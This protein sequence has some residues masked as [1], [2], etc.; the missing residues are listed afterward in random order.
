MNTHAINPLWFQPITMNTLHLFQERC[1]VMNSWTP[2]L[3]LLTNSSD[4]KHYLEAGLRP[5][6]V[7]KFHLD[8]HQYPLH[9]LED[10]KECRVSDSG[11]MVQIDDGRLE[12]PVNAAV[13][14]CRF[15]P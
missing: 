8:Y 10:L 14:W 3:D 12:V 11:L 5:H 9:Q 13:L 6:L 2:L 4:A 1:G 15:E 7:S